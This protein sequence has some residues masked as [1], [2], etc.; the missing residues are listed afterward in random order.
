MADRVRVAV[1]ISGRGTNMAALLYAAKREDCP[2]EIVLV[3]ANDPE[4]RGLTLAAA[5]GVPT[6]AQSHKGMERS[7]FDAILDREI[8]KAGADYVVLAGYM[9]ILSDDFVGKWAGRLLNIHP[10]LLPKYPGLDTHRRA[11]D[12]GDTVSGCTVHLVTPALD[13]GPILGQ[14]E[15]AILPGDTPEKLATRI[16]LA[17]H[18]LYP[19]VLEELVTRERDPDWI[20]AKV[21]ELAMELPEVAAK[22]SH[23]SPGWRIATSKSGKFFAYVSIR[24]HGEDAISLL[25]KT[26]G[27]DEQA[28][29]IEAEPDIY[30]KPAYY[31]PSGW[32]AIRLDRPNVDWEH[33]ANWLRKSWS[34]VAPKKLQPMAEFLG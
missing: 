10:S 8:R 22:S 21:G 2:Y 1:L 28:A 25:V 23:G 16:R 29:L 7:E 9:R 12:A 30:Y 18:Q 13:E 31:G 33:I 14:T 34:F 17:E 24:H 6:F 15:V 5:E 11:I 19:R 3:A 4:A 27:P 20:V 32:I 26:S